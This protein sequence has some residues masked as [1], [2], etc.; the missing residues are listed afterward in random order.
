MCVRSGCPCALE[1]TKLHST[2]TCVHL[3]PLPLMALLIGKCPQLPMTPR[4][5]APAHCPSFSP[6]ILASF[7][8][9][10]RIDTIVEVAYQSS[11]NQLGADN[12][13]EV[14]AAATARSEMLMEN[15]FD[16]LGLSVNT[17]RLSVCMCECAWECVG[18]RMQ[19]R[20]L[21]HGVWVR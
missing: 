12:L 16:A 13:K 2:L 18:E 9:D 21:A 17:V 19:L 6:T 14:C 5:R 3:L 1:V 11:L 20:A 7:P 4:P 15:G 8:Q 10:V